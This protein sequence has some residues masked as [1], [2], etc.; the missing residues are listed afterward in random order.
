MLDDLKFDP[1]N[2]EFL[3]GKIEMAKKVVERMDGKAMVITGGAGPM[4]TAI[5]IRDASSF[6]RDLVKDPENAD[7]LL[8]FCVDCNLKWIEYNQKVFG[9]VVV[10]MA[11]P[12]TST[13]LLSPQLFQRFSKPYIQKQLN[14]IK[15]FDRDYSGSTYSGGHTKKIWNDIVEVGYPSFSV[16]NCADL[17][18]LKAEIGDKVKISGNVPPV[19]VMKN[20]TID[21]V[22]HSVQE[23]LIKGSD[24]PCGFESCNRMSGSN[25]NIS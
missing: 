3:Q 23:C 18:E 4:T 9:K 21:D 7:R 24:S 17:A 6:L 16:D 12:A 15:E 10:S 19:E 11:D 2:N 20:G 22:I 14:G 25:W 1:E 5:A 8:D 13:N